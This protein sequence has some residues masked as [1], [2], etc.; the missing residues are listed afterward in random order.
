MSQ[1]AGFLAL[2]G[3]PPGIDRLRLHSSLD[4]A[5]AHR[6]CVVTGA[7]GWGKTMAVTSW[8]RS[9]PTVWMRPEGRDRFGSG[10]AQRL[11]DSLR[12][13]G[14]AP[15]V[16]LSDPVTDKGADEYVDGCC[17]WLSQTL[18]DDLVLVIDDLQTSTPD[19]VAMRILAGLCRGGPDRLHLL[20]LS[21]RDLP[22]SLERLRGRGSLAEVDARD[23]AFDVDEVSRL[24]QA[25]VG[26]HS[27]SLAEQV[28]QRTGGWPAAASLVM[29]TLRDVKP[30]RQS[31]LLPQLM[32]PL[33]Y[34]VEEVIEEEP[35]PVRQVLH[36]LAVSSGKGEAAATVTGDD[37]DPSCVVDLVRRGLVHAVQGHVDRWSLVAP[38]QYYFDQQ[39]P[40]AF[41]VLLHRQA[42]RDHLG[43]GAPADALWHLR[44]SG[45]HSACASLLVEHGDALVSGGRFDAVLEAAELPAEHL[46][47]ERIQ[48][49][50]GQAWQA[51]GQWASAQECFRRAGDAH[52]E[53]EPAL[54][55]RVALVAYGQAQF[56]EV[57]VVCAR[58]RLAAESTMDEVRVLSLA[59]NASRMVGDYA[60]CR[61]QA[62]RAMAA[63][64]R[65][66]QP[67]A[68]ASVY[69]AQAK[70]AFAEG[71]QR[72]A[73]G[74]SQ[75]AIE[76]AE[77]AGDVLQSH[78]AHMV[79]ACQLAETGQSEAALA[80]IEGVL[81]LGE[82]CA[83]RPLRAQ[84]LNLRG[85]MRT[86]RGLVESALDDLAASRDLAQQLGSGFLAWPLCGLG[87][88]DRMRGRLASARA[89]YEEALALAEPCHDVLALG[90]ALTG[91]A[92]VRAVDDTAAARELAERA[93]ALGEG[94]RAVQAW[95]TRGWITLLE[96]DRE[97]A[98]VD[99][100]LA[101]D[102]ARARCDNP[103]LAE[104]L[105]LTVLAAAQ[106]RQHRGMLAEA[107]EILREADRP[108]EEAQARLVDSRLGRDI[109]AEA[110][111]A[112][113]TVRNYGVH[114]GTE[115]A[116]G[117][118]AVLTRFAPS[119]SIH[120]L[121][122]FRVVRDGETVPKNAWQ[123]RKARD[124]LKIL[125]ARRR[126]VP[127]ERLIEL[128]WPGSDPTK[129]GNRLSVLLT[130]VRE[131]LQPGAGRSDDGPLVSDGTSVWLDPARV[132]ID[133]EEFLTEAAAA[134]DADRGHRHD[135]TAQL[136]AA[137]RMVGGDFLA[138]DPH[139]EWA[140]PLGEEIRATHMA[141]LRALSAQLRA[142]RDLDGAV[143][144]T[145]RLLQHDPYDEQAH[146]DLV[147]I[148]L[149][150]GHPDEAYRRYRIYVQQM[151]EFGVEPRPFQQLDGQFRRVAS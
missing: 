34:L 100:A 118:L 120:A 69:L 9:A 64:E 1:G 113:R 78:W 87:D 105:V 82:S 3:A 81:Q 54:A 11:T 40:P 133:V 134:L 137:E 36:R 83:E 53:L 31:S 61:E 75:S 102:T 22:F 44:A 18:T 117:P 143:G 45:D 48:R 77:A 80:H 139:S 71:D 108:I 66:G 92:R 76:A 41:R 29:E 47:D 114:V 131:V 104:A 58:A 55:W 63:A 57:L 19:P 125:V 128:L 10:F 116:A 72:R 42:A 106:P 2:A 111:M 121:G 126:P 65:C 23:L 85:T 38:V 146:L 26:T 59:A 68:R 97:A 93:L 103:G 88:I 56:D 147:A 28:W 98:A 136:A 49:V 79:R 148:Q 99:A 129:A 50:V 74:Y 89:R 33:Q 132:R 20:L 119:V 90:S 62:G 70:L 14:P 101:A 32:R 13:R 144:C 67:A 17:R 135:V 138:G 86:H 96:G 30:G 46:A 109:G 73:D 43:R 140:M 150:A 123:S 4:A 5:V 52:G 7:A 24:L 37:V 127:R 16:C 142:G 12:S 39:L 107:I 91:L 94:A 95:L 8:S 35:E 130:T 27:A 110:A 51:R 122:D 115:V 25:T 6:V 15:A 112:E 60:G 151:A 21:R 141:V 149:E 145:L 84:A 124:L